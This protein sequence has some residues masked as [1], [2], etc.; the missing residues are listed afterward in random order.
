ML[1]W[2]FGVFI[3]MIAMLLGTIQFSG[4]VFD[5]FVPS[6][7]LLSGLILTFFTS[8]KMITFDKILGKFLHC[9]IWIFIAIMIL[10]SGITIY[11]IAHGFDLGPTQ[12]AALWIKN[13]SHEKDHVF[14]Y[15][16]SSFPEVFFTNSFNTYSMGIEPMTLK[17]YDPALYWK[18]YNIF[19]NMHYCEESFDCRDIIEEEKERLQNVSPEIMEMKDRENSMKILISIKNDF[20]AD[21]IFSDSRN[22]TKTIELNPQMIDQ[23]FYVRSERVN[24][25]LSEVTVFKLK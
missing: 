4:R 25:K 14:L 11:T 22:F 15:N 9:G 21:F 13:N 2:I 18:Y 19:Y 10:S 3:F 24:G 7:F 8:Q 23:K 5:F 17:N 6:V 20:K 12:K 1:I 16:W